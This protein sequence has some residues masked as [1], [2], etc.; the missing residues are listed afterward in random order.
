MMFIVTT[1]SVPLK[2]VDQFVEESTVS[3]SLIVMDNNQLANDIHWRTKFCDHI[4]AT[5]PG[6]G[7]HLCNC[8]LH[9]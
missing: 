2:S 9:V 7:G 6:E 5:D 3:H 8:D 1:H 4:C